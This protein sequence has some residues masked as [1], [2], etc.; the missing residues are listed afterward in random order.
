[1]GEPDLPID[2]GVRIGTGAFVGQNQQLLAGDHNF[3]K[4]SLTPSVTLVTELPDDINGSWYTGE[5]HFGIKDAVLE[6][7][8]A[9]RHMVELK[10]VLE[11]RAS[12]KGRPIPPLLAALTDGGPD[13]NTSHFSVILGWVA[14][15]LELDLDMIVAT[16]TGA[17]QSYQD[18]VERV[19]SLLNMLLQNVSL[20]RELMTPAMEKLLKDCN[21]MDVRAH[22][23][24]CARAG[25][26]ACERACASGKTLR[27]HPRA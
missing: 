27:L 15:F 9:L 2:T 3:H 23:R 20:A 17:G 26:W 21:T 12:N 25:V 22:R 11:K 13:H 19:M 4:A 24:A 8:S 18:P 1:M 14:L 16:R 6:P 10:K 7:S 5:V